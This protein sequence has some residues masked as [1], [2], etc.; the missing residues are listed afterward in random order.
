MSSSRDELALPAA[1][2]PQEPWPGLASFRESDAAFFRGRHEE[3]EQLL[4][5]VRRSSLTVLFGRSGLGKTSLL[6]AGLFPKL[7]EHDYFPIYLR[8]DHS[9][10][11]KDGARQ[12]LDGVLNA[13]VSG[14]LEAPLPLDTD[15]LWSYF[16]RKDAEGN[17]C[18]MWNARN[19]LTTPVIVLDQFEELFTHNTAPDA[20]T[21]GD[22]FFQQLADLVENQTPASLREAFA[23]R[24]AHASD[25]HFEATSVRVVLSLR[26]DF[27]AQ[28]ERKRSVMPRIM[29]ER[30]EIRAMN[31][32]RAVQVVREAGSEVV[33]ER[34]ATEIVRKLASAD[35]KSNAS[36][37]QPLA[38]SSPS[39][40]SRS[41]VSPP[42]DSSSA[43]GDLHHQ[44]D[45]LVIEPALLSLL[46]R[47]L[48][49]R[50]I[51]TGQSQIS[52]T[53][54]AASTSDI[55]ASY[56]DDC[57][58]N[59]ESGEK[60]RAF[61]EDC[62]LTVSGFRD[63]V[64]VE[65]A[66]LELTQRDMDALIN[67][68][69][70]RI[71]DRGGQ[72]R[73]EF[74]HDVLTGIASTRREGRRVRERAERARQDELRQARAAQEHAEQQLRGAREEAA[75]RNE[76]ARAKTRTRV[77]VGALAIAL[78]AGSL[79]IFADVQ[80]R[81]ATRA[82]QAASK[83]QDL[84]E[85]RGEEARQAASEARA[86]EADQRALKERFERETV[87]GWA[88]SNFTEQM[89]RTV[90]AEE[91]IPSVAPFA[92]AQEAASRGVAI[93]E[94]MHVL[95]P[96]PA[97]YIDY[98]QVLPGT[99]ADIIFDSKGRFIVIT[100]DGDAYL[101][102]PADA[103]PFRALRT[104][105]T[106]PIRTAA[107]LKAPVGDPHLLLVSR[108]NLMTTDLAGNELWREPLP[109]IPK[110]QEQEQ[111]QEQDP[112]QSPDQ[113][114]SQDS[115]AWGVA[116]QHTNGYIY[117]FL[118]ERGLLTL[119][120]DS[121][122]Q[123]SSWTVD[124]ARSPT[125]LGLQS[126]AISYESVGLTLDDGKPVADVR[127]HR[128][129][130][131]RAQTKES[132][133]D[134]RFESIQLSF[135]TSSNGWLETCQSDCRGTPM[136]STGVEARM[137]ALREHSAG[138][139]VLRAVINDR[140]G[141]VAFPRYQGGS[142]LFI[143]PTLDRLLILEDMPPGFDRGTRSTRITLLAPTTLHV[144][145]T[146]HPLARELDAIRSE[147]TWLFDPSTQ[148][149]VC[150]D[151]HAE[152]AAGTHIPLSYDLSLG[153]SLVPERVQASPVVRSVCSLQF[154]A[155]DV[156]V[157][158]VDDY[159]KKT[160][161]ISPDATLVAVVRDDET[162][163]VLSI[164]DVA[165]PIQTFGSRHSIWNQNLVWS[166]DGSRLAATTDAG[167]A[168]YDVRTGSQ[169]ALVS[170]DFAPDA[171]PRLFS[172]DGDALLCAD[173]TGA[174]AVQGLS[175]PESERAFY[176][177]GN[178]LRLSERTRVH[179]TLD[180][181]VVFT[182]WPNRVEYAPAQS[183]AS[184]RLGLR[185]TQRLL[186]VTFDKPLA[187]SPGRQG[188]PLR[189]A[190]PSD[191]A[192]FLR[193]SEALNGNLLAR[194]FVDEPLTENIDTDI[195][196]LSQKLP[197]QLATLVPAEYSEKRQSFVQSALD[198][199][200]QHLVIV[201]DALLA[202][203]SDALASTE[204]DE[205]LAAIPD[206]MKAM[207]EIFDSM[208]LQLLRFARINTRPHDAL[209]SSAVEAELINLV[210]E[211]AFQNG[212]VG[213]PEA[214]A[215]EVLGER[216]ARSENLNSELRLRGAGLA[217][218]SAAVVSQERRA[219]AMARA[220]ALAKRLEERWLPSSERANALGMFGW[221]VPKE[222]ILSP[223]EQLEATIDSFDQTALA[224]L[225]PRDVEVG[226]ADLTA[227]L[228]R[229]PLESREETAA[230][231][232]TL[233]A[234]LYLETTDRRH[235]AWPGLRDG[236]AMNFAAR[237]HSR[238]RDAL[239]AYLPTLT[240]ADARRALRTDYEAWLAANREL[241]D[242][243]A[244]N[245]ETGSALAMVLAAANEPTASIVER[246]VRHA[247]LRDPDSSAAIEGPN[248]RLIALAKKLP[249][250]G[251]L[252]HV[253]DAVFGHLLLA[254]PPLKPEQRSEALA[255][256][257]ILLDRLARPL[258]AEAQLREALA[259]NNRNEW[260]RV[261]L[262]SRLI[263]SGRIQKGVEL[264]T[265][266]RNGDDEVE[267]PFALQQLAFAAIVG[268]TGAKDV[269]SSLE[270]LE[271]HAKDDW[272]VI[273]TKVWAWY[274]LLL[275]DAREAFRRLEKLNASDTDFL[276][277]AR[278]HAAAGNLALADAALDEA[279]RTSLRKGDAASA[280]VAAAH[281]G[282]R[283]PD[284]PPSEMFTKACELAEQDCLLGS[285]PTLH[286]RLAEL[287]VTRGS[288]PESNETGTALH[289]LAMLH[290]AEATRIRGFVNSL[291]E[292]P[293]AIA[294]NEQFQ[295]L[296]RDP[297]FESLLAAAASPPQG[298]ERAAR[299]A[300]T[301]ASLAAELAPLTNDARE[302]AWRHALRDG[303][304]GR[305]DASLADAANEHCT[306]RA[307]SLLREALASGLNQA[308]INT[309]PEL[310]SL[311]PLVSRTTKP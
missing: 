298:G 162:L 57:F 262:A 126:D 82:M 123:P 116:A 244:L 192:L 283:S 151:F 70:L 199:H 202:A 90:N 171:S 154:A 161:S 55:L 301:Y 300:A 232:L 142:P 37:T 282:A 62:L 309:R 137:E 60:A 158:G 139:D 141:S 47:E 311:V 200:R 130:A 43:A 26:E 85:I 231:A 119:S 264:A 215:L 40:G 159:R 276:L 69:L 286:L 303:P 120:P 240:T 263:F 131:V 140:W 83:A 114:V 251:Q 24:T 14:S 93:A 125:N 209:Q 305:P 19:R 163:E 88:A 5:C 51:A 108:T 11:A 7:R 208:P 22:E 118:P 249:S 77:L 110:A 310:A 275:G 233:R 164:G 107:F 45:A 176:R 242:L 198:S 138:Y 16:H 273:A 272:D 53:L 39:S 89:S 206:S 29:Q 218:Q 59:T 234:R 128:R 256:R 228:E 299:L 172:R 290:L 188:A 160:L 277:L 1:L 229:V 191:D 287:L 201:A 148:R 254:S 250:R 238:I 20:L 214:R 21:R 260:A 269:A 183:I 270:A 302:V 246:L 18:E 253:E 235:L 220:I 289:L 210:E 207:A 117:V 68:R 17:A 212:T 32:E 10:H 237:G 181:S 261:E 129:V 296:S 49:R 95:A 147:S 113:S 67:S 105:D 72:R 101:H 145:L 149:L 194:V 292:A 285:T 247:A 230:R 76:R 104:P 52:S 281:I 2:S 179:R 173:Q 87:A 213:V 65:N 266:T 106:G 54:I 216:I 225:S 248:A 211:D 99:L 91:A 46:C 280:A 74:T 34:E 157:E 255:Y 115:F 81:K 66:L 150:I 36:L 71:D 102:Q 132:A 12:I 15:S 197:R 297:I 96:A 217:V 175:K 63:S 56:Y 259:A 205:A 279:K 144:E 196:T 153:G 241:V 152:I 284:L 112:T 182:G 86:A 58:R 204:L 61:V 226:I 193:L 186:P 6:Q 92:I 295:A 307:I 252:C 169:I 293:W 224:K 8:I 28:L 184:E 180:G 227:A 187:P 257:G 97:A 174:L 30:F 122:R 78:V 178:N 143:L 135:R 258:E 44:L 294:R 306:L 288:K 109:Q 50:R 177:L 100:A 35:T 189:V 219:S 170:A 25:F 42:G 121:T 9:P 13:I 195:A 267:K 64:A 239:L 94:F 274:H 136:A 222:S 243:D 155:D 304:F 127:G 80:R 4:A 185:F 203:Q 190:L 38:S 236:L 308:D 48:N 23:A 79:G 41:G 271:S 221:N 98:D 31:G 3:A 223:R 146:T 268:E 291:E 27:L 103:N 165:T 111:E 133:S 73:L 124:F 167:V 168:V 278:T 265:Q 156:A 84:A 33:Q 166:S 134:D 75:I 245:S